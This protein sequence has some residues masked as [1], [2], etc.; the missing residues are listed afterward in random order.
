MIRVGSGDGSDSLAF[1]AGGSQRL[2]ITSG[3]D[4]GIGFGGYSG[5]RLTTRGATSDSTNFAFFVENSGTYGLF[6]VRNDGYIAMNVRPTYSPYY[7]AVSGR[8]LIINSSGELG[9]SASIRKAKINIESETDVSWLYDLNPVKFNYRKKD[10]KLN[11][12]NEAEEEQRY[13]LIAEE[14]E[15]VNT[16]FCWYNVNEEGDKDLAGV[17]YK[18]LITPM[19]KAIQEQQTIIED[20]KSRIETLEG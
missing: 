12:L 7:F 14:V 18:M 3:G 11:Y 1:Y 20:L 15:E 8:D 9:T 4:V 16:D 13:G 2:T 5:Y 6:S 10:K 19:I 17:D